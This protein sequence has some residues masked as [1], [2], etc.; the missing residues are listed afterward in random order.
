MLVSFREVT[1]REILNNDLTYNNEQALATAL[2][3]RDDR[4]YLF[5]YDNYSAALYSIIK[6]MAGDTGTAND[7][8]QEVFI[9]C[10]QNIENYDAAN[11][12]LFIWLI[13][14]ARN[15]LAE[16]KRP[17]YANRRAVRSA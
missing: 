4:A 12:K 1:F 8:L 5:L 14:I 17:T 15:S 2:K 11:E 13:S 9:R 7:L 6:Q 10:R 16:T 3:A